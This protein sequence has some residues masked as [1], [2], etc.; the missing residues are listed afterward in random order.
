MHD[1]KGNSPHDI[2]VNRPPKVLLVDDNPDCRYLLSRNLLKESPEALIL[3]CSTADFAINAAACA[4]SAIIVHR[5]EPD[6]VKLISKI[7]EAV[8]TVPIVFV[9]EKP[10]L[11]P[12]ALA[13]GA[14]R[15]LDYSKLVLLGK[16]V[17]ELSGQNATAPSVGP[18]S[19]LPRAP[20][21]IPL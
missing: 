19:I 2:L 11:E 10:P 4:P 6:G 5:P 16:V 14:A 13:A 20:R 15:C 12:V 3:E 7:R 18:A 21:V 9:V 17:E 8:P 1:G